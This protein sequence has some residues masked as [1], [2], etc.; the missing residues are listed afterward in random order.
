MGAVAFVGVS[1]E[2]PDARR[3]A[4]RLVAV[5]EVGMVATTLGEYEVLVGVAATSREALAELVRERITTQ[6]GVR[7]TEITEYHEVF[8]HSYTWAR[9][10]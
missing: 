4:E 6:P 1:V 2:G 9:L 7:R 5:P 8:K 10:V 3:V